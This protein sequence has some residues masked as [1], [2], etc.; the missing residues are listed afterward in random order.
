MS[1]VAVYEG[2]FGAAEAERLLWR[3]G[4][5]PRKGEA[6]ALAQLGLEGAVHSLAHPGLEQLVGPNPVDENG[7]PLAPYDAWGHDHVWW[8]DRMVRTS[9]PLVERM[10]LVWHDWFAT[11]NEGVDSQ[12]LMLAQNELFRRTGLGS[13]RTLVE[14]VTRDPAMLL[15]LNGSDNSKWS[16]N[17]NYGRE[18]MELFTL[19]AG[20][21]YTEGDV[22]QNARALTGFRNDWKQGVGNVDFRFD[23]SYHDT[24][25][26]TIF[27]RSGNWGW[28][29]SVRLAV[30]HVD[31][32][33]FFAQKLWSYFVPVAPDPATL[34][35][36][37]RLYV[38]GGRAVG[39]VV[40][41]IL[42]H[43]ALYTGPPLVKPPAVYNAGLL[44]RIGRGIDT[45]AWSWLGA[46][47]GQQLFYPPN[48]G[49]WDDTRWLD[50]ATWRGRWW[51]VA[52][53]LKPYALDPGTASQPFDAQSLVQGALDF[54][55]DPAHGEA[56]KNALIGFAQ[57]VLA[58]AA[59]AGWK[60]KQY[61]VMAQN[62]LRH[63][64][65]VAPELQTS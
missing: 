47:A 10:A 40:E 5:G 45:T 6:E 15:W 49:G 22:R 25:M 51:I 60:R 44:R 50:T 37:E 32:P 27:K 26:K 62:G 53:V 39:P 42:K 1:G 64:I 52:Y 28:K 20:R 17:E 30:T 38:E 56:T 19:G 63:L 11:S 14:N 43:P 4:F 48:V 35:S 9:R 33:S 23:P 8:L 57:A 12:R 21:G 41:A 46:M 24:G 18:M 61:P 7:N 31:H 65:A 2:S 55:N 34:A 58:D 3:A 29:D 54:W 36:L 13:F 59:K 16:P